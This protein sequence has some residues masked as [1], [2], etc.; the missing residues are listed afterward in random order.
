[1][2]SIWTLEDVASYLK[3]TE[4]TVVSWV[5]KGILPGKKVETVWQFIRKDIEEWMNQQ[6][7]SHKTGHHNDRLLSI[8]EILSPEK[9]IFTS[10]NSKKDLFS[11]LSKQAVN[12]GFA[13]SEELILSDLWNREALMSTGIGLGI[14][15]PH[16]R[17][18]QLSTVELF[19]LFNDNIISD[20]ES[21]DD[22]PVHLVAFV[23]AGAHMHKEYLKV[24]ASVVNL[25]KNQNVREAALACSDAKSAY[26]IITGKF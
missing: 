16:L 18:P 8:E 25:L 14:A 22:Q 5:E 11:F 4:K 21:I 2:S 19:L 12:S 7:S 9:L 3:V 10:I 17:L 13:A 1:M 15:V 26:R 23:L 6:L 20:Y 24:L